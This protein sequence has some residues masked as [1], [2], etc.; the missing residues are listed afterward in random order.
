MKRIVMLSY[1]DTKIGPKVFCSHPKELLDIDLTQEIC[2]FVDFYDLDGYL[3]HVSDDK[4]IFN[5][6]FEIF[7]GLSRGNIET[8]SIAVITEKDISKEEE[9]RIVKRIN[10]FILLI[11]NDKDI[12]F[13]FYTLPD[14]SETYTCF[15]K[16]ALLQYLIHK[17]YE[18]IK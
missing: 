17:L 2:K 5:F 4:R 3:I 10:K 14:H 12:Y 1:F 11:K 6:G 15:E 18:G 16:K 7:S 13:G 8:L 9:D